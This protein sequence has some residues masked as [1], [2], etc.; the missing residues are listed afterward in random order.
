MGI[1]KLSGKKKA[2]PRQKPVTSPSA[3]FQEAENKYS[4]YVSLAILYLPRVHEDTWNT[5]V[6]ISEADDT[7]ANRSI[8]EQ[9]LN[10]AAVLPLSDRVLFQEALLKFADR[11]E[12]TDSIAASIKTYDERC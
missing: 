10:A 6:G 11:N 8:K 3:I 7:T 4:P 1:H 2:L 12:F 5:L 9:V